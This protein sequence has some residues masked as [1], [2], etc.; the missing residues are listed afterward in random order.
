VTYP[1]GDFLSEFCIELFSFD[2]CCVTFPGGAQICAQFPTIP[3]DNGEAVKQALAQVNSALAPLQPVFNI[4]DAIIAV[5]NCVQAIPDAITNL[6]VTGLV[7][8]VPDMVEKVQRLL[9]LIPQLSLPLLLVEVIDCMIN[10]LEALKAQLTHIAAEYQR[11]IAAGLAAAEPGNVA[12]R[13]IVDCAELDLNAFLEFANAGLDPLNRL[14]GLVS[15]F[16]GILGIDA[17]APVAAVTDPAL[18]E[19]SLTPLTILID[20]FKLV[21]DSIPIP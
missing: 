14:I 8:C 5:F 9:A 15:A 18:I 3:T 16:L 12:L 17:L 2:Q 19:A 6:D 11:I 7:E 1:I 21:R 20:S 13:T 10:A 4:I